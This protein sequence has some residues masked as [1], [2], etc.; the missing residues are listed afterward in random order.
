MDDMSTRTPIKDAWAHQLKCNTMHFFLA[1]K[2]LTTSVRVTKAGLQPNFFLKASCKL[3][4][5]RK[6]SNFISNQCSKC[7][8]YHHSCLRNN[9]QLSVILN[10][11]HN[12]LTMLSCNICFSSFVTFDCIIA[13][14]T[15]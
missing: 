10:S 8:R 7:H 13:L 1:T 4:L 3:E 6:D 15:T 14:C 2:Y 12:R 5:K 11:L 9:L